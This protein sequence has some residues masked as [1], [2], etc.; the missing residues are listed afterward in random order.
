MPHSRGHYRQDQGFAD[1]ILVLS[2]RR[3]LQ[4]SAAAAD[5]VM[6]RNAAGDISINQIASKTN[7][8]VF[9]LGDGTLLRTGEAE[10][11]SNQYGGSGVFGDAGPQYPLTAMNVGQQITPRTTNKVKGIK[12]LSVAVAYMIGTVDLTAF[13]CRLDRLPFTGGAAPT[14]V[15][16]LASGVN[17]LSLVHDDVNMQVTE[18]PLTGLQTYR[19][20]D[21]TEY[22]LE[23]AVQTAATGTFR[24]YGARVKV[25]F[26]FN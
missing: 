13:T 26:N 23:I 5:A 10:T 11:F 12:F 14:P 20:A 19:T 9:A 1:G 17:G 18:I 16:L 21:L 15:N 6:T 3:V 4:F 7:Q 24:L 22:L 8:Y 2:P 25:E